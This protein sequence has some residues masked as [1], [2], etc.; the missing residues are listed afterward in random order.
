MGVFVG[1]IDV[2]EGCTMLAADEQEAQGVGC[3]VCCPSSE[4]SD[5]LNGRQGERSL[6]ALVSLV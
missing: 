2:E 6:L 3:G 5:G 4:F 1:M